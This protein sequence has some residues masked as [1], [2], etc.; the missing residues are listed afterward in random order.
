MLKYLLYVVPVISFS[1][2]CEIKFEKWYDRGIV[3]DVF[4]VQTLAQGKPA[5]T[6]L[7]IFESNLN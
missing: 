5:C 6:I 2:P 4:D 3:R 1:W 7:S